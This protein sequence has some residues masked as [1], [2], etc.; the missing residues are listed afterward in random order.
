MPRVLP[1]SQAYARCHFSTPNADARLLAIVT[2]AVGIS[3][4]YNRCLDDSRR[5]YADRFA[6]VGYCVYTK[7]PVP[8]LAYGFNKLV[9]VMDTFGRLPELK[10]AVYLDAD[11]LIVNMN[12]S[13]LDIARRYAAADIVFAS[14][15]LG[16]REREASVLS[17]TLGFSKTEVAKYPIQGGAMMFKNSARAAW[18]AE[19]AFREGRQWSLDFAHLSDR[20]AWIKVAIHNPEVFDKHV[21]ILEPGVLEVTTREYNVSTSALALHAGGGGAFGFLTAIGLG[22]TGSKYGYMYKLCRKLY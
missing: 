15:E 21:V 6:G 22:G 12:V 4:P 18:L 1:E 2:I 19:V 14:E 9:A 5:A 10:Y 13:V 11:A 16:N 20:A 7:Q 3:E 17:K 8:T